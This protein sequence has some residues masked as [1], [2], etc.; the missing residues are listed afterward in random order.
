MSTPTHP[1]VGYYDD[2]ETSTISNTAYRRVMYTDGNIQIVYMSLLPNEEIGMEVHPKTTQFFRVEQ[3]VGIAIIGGVSYAI[4]NGIAFAVPKGVYHN[5]INVS[6]TEELK[7]YT[8]YTPPQ[9]PP[10][11]VHLLKP[12][13]D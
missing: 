9:H 3:G 7:L 5:I 4:N 6:S 2:I 12:Q 10:G 11:T 8:I 1:W 13:N